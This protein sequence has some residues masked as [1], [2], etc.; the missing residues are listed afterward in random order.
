MSSVHFLIG[1]TLGKY[2]VLEHIGHG[3]MSEVYKGQQAQLNRLVAIKVLHPFLA[4][5]EGFVVRFQREARIVAT[6]RHP[7]IVQV[8]DFDYNEDLS[9]YYMVME[10]IEG[11]TLKDRLIHGALPAHETAQI[12]ISMAS[13]LDYAHQR[14]MIHRDIKPANILFLNEDDPI[15]TDFGIARMLNLSGL[16][17]SGAMVGT[18]AYMAPEVGRGKAGS[19]ASDIY[20]LSVVLYEAATGTLPFSAETPMGMVMEHLNSAPLPPSQA[21]A[22]IPP[23]LEEV[24]LRGL[25]KEPEA[26]FEN[27]GAMATA[28][29][30]AMGIVPDR[31][32]TPLP[33]A[34]PVDVEPTSDER[35]KSD[36]R[37]SVQEQTGDY[38]IAPLAEATTTAKPA[39]RRR[40][41]LLLGGLLALII[42]IIGGTALLQGS[43]NRPW[44][45]LP[46]PPSPS[47]TAAPGHMTAT[48][49]SS[50]TPEP[51]ATPTL[52][53]A[54]EFALAT[55]TP[56]PTP[57]CTPRVRAERVRL[58][59]SSTVAPGTA[60]VAH[61][62]L[63][64]SGN[65]PW[66]EDTALHLT[67]ETRLGAPS[68]FTVS[69]VLP[70]E[71]IQ[72]FIPMT[73]PEEIGTY[74]VTW[75]M[76]LADDQSFG[77]RIPLEIVVDDLATLTP[78]PTADLVPEPTV[79]L[80]M[81]LE[82]PQ[83]VRWRADPSRGRWSGLAR[84]QASGG[85]GHYR[86]FLEEVSSTTELVHG[87]LHFEWHYCQALPLNL[88]VLSG[89]SVLNWRGE[90][91]Y[92]APEACE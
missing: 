25:Q 79:S 80:T 19:A 52:W 36:A 86:Y 7:S 62:S 49:T 4:D 57:V 75:E 12:G 46:S 6:L 88:W 58:A 47:A 42:V 76:R 73:A 63:Q 89:G 60:L 70:D 1:K 83:L 30:V 68:V 54:R 13:A 74:V 33:A 22:S 48:A 41:G 64:N 11:P 18:P 45:W 3:G 65:C 21:G 53:V 82:T 44:T 43:S 23:E 24:I 61:I 26:R 17:A 92:P 5:E 66:P 50:P 35:V 20:S 38:N 40:L 90:I 72:L 84:V 77:S 9:L 10:Y 14:N 32:P 85:T 31:T 29:R 71:S 51:S 34:L 8:F 87:E 15:L 27:A 78:T 37:L 39:V 67:G 28:L 81:T 69:H 16:T 56:T 2:Q 55:H 59:P 91:P